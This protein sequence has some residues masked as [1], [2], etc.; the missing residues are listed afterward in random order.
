MMQ[1]K[2]KRTLKPP[3]AQPQA[4]LPL[5]PSDLDVKRA[6]IKERIARAR[7]T[8]VEWDNPVAI[9]EWDRVFGSL[10]DFYGLDD[11][12]ECVNP[13]LLLYALA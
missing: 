11:P 13:V 2:G 10:H 12:I 5:F 7:A 8:E 6:R 4:Q 9:R 1:K 3:P